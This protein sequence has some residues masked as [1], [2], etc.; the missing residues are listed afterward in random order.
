MTK[1]KGD[2]PFLFNGDKIM[3]VMTRET[4][5]EKVRE[6]CAAEGVGYSENT[7]LFVARDKDE[8][9]GYSIFEITDKLNI[10]NISTPQILWNSI[11]DGLFRAT[12]NFAVESG[13]KSARID[14][15]LLEKLS[16]NIIPTEKVTEEIGDCEEFLQSIKRCGR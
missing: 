2:N 10:I 3:I 13:V 12:L 11:G 16:G 6:I 4:D 8:I 9:L 7:K 5:A 14:K 15:T 1:R